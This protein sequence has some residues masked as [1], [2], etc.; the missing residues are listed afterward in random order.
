MMDMRTLAIINI[1]G[2][3][4]DVIGTLYLAY[5]LLGGEHGPLRTL[6]KGVTYGVLFGIGYGVVLGPVFGLASGATTG[7]T[8]GWELSRAAR[9]GPKPGF[10]YESTMSAIRGFGFAVGASYLFGAR[11]GITFGV[12]GTAGQVIAYRFGV[13]PS[14][15]YAPA[16]KPG[17]SRN[18]ILAV[19]NRTVGYAIAGYISALVGHQHARALVFGLETG[20][21]I[22]VVTAVANFCMPFVEWRVDH[23]PERRMGIAGIGMILIGFALQSIQ[24][25]VTLIG[26]TVR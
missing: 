17:I 26:H 10:W 6:T 21:M 9:Q 7:I 23:M 2:S 1:A 16:T 4:L 5:D 13:R 8:L 3:S 14:L 20:V 24:Y 22:G 18:Q 15:D 19:V 25:W 12:L 11:F